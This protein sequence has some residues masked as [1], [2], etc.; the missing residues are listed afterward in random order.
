MK[1]SEAM[2]KGFT[3]IE[4]QCFGPVAIFSGGRMLKVFN[5]AFYFL[6][7]KPCAVCALGAMSLGL[8]GRFISID[9][10]EEAGGALQFWKNEFGESLA[11]S[12][13]AGMPID[14]IAGILAAEGF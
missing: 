8:Y 1:P 13:D 7:E 14:V 4:Q 9:D 11:E 10:R 3:G 2:L 12:A 5:D 6:G